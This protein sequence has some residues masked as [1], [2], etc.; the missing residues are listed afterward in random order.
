LFKLGVISFIGTGLLILEGCKRIT[1]TDSIWYGS[2]GSQGAV[3]IHTLA[4]VPSQV[5]SLS[6]F[7]VLWDNSSDPLICT[8]SSTFANWK[9][10]LEKL[11]SFDNT[12]SYDNTQVI[13]QAVKI[14]DKITKHENAD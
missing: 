2:L 6:Q 3:Q 5:I 12:C 8:N 7:A 4:N 9:A 13:S 10:N 11:C 14:L 1:I